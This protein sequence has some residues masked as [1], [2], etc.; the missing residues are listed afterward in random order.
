MADT[1]EQTLNEQAASDDV[2]QYLEEIRLYEQ[3]AGPW[4]T[5]A[6]KILKKY[7]NKREPN[8]QRRRVNFL[9]AMV[10]TLG[11][12]LY[13]RDPKTDISRRFSAAGDVGRV[14]ADVLEKCVSYFVSEYGFGSAMRKAVRG[15]LLPGRGTVWCRYVPHMGRVEA[16]GEN[17]KPDYGGSQV[18]DEQNPHDT[19]ESV[20]WEEVAID[21]VHFDDFGHNIAR[22]WDEVWLLWRRVFMDRS[23]L[24]QRFPDVGSKL[25]LDHKPKELTG[26]DKRVH[27]SKAT[28][29]EI[30]DK[31]RGCTVWLHK[32][33]PDLLDERQDM[34]KLEGFFPVPEPL[35]ANLAD[36]DLIPVPDYVQWQDQAMQLDELTARIASISKSLKVAGVRDASAQ[37]LDRLLSEGVENALIPVDQ[38][39]IFAE[40]GGIK[41]AVELLPMEEIAQTLLH[42]YEAR[43][44]VKEELYEVTGLSDVIRGVSDPQETATAQDIKQNFATMR[45]DD[46][47]RQVYEFA[48]DTVKIIG[49]I[50]A[51]HFALET[52][53]TISGVRLIDTKATQKFLKSLPPQAQ[54]PALAQLFPD[55][56]DYDQDELR[57]CL[58]NPTWEEVMQLLRD[59]PARR[60]RL[61]I[62]TKSTIKQDEDDEKQARVE[63]IQAVGGFIKE[64][65]AA[66]AQQPLLVPLMA[67]LLMFGVR[68]FPVGKELEETFKLTI[69]KLEQQAQNPQQKPDPDVMKIQAQQQTEQMKAQLQQ[70]A[71]QA[72]VQADAQIEQLRVASEQKIEAMRLEY[73]KQADASAQQWQ[74]WQVDQQNKAELAQNQREAMMQA[75]ID[76]MK[77]EMQ[78][79]TQ[80]ILAHI[81]AASAIEVARISAQT[82]SGEAAYE[83]EAAGEQ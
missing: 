25:V 62:E 28:I 6:R 17:L 54:L 51:N 22:T 74:A 18:T 43:D 16:L 56:A 80:V 19:V 38:W 40:K 72:K 21:F 27:G 60:F 7:K 58:A 81:K 55:I 37:G 4:E 41:G 79:Q 66:G 32:D 5:Q 36:D 12:A 73:Q 47:Q 35:F 33:W 71:Q 76:Q 48:R 30:W 14:T 42:I 52:I 78:A 82:D 64:A 53:K 68:A 13:M 46:R 44:K 10:Q 29:Y 77:M 23:E 24:K 65:M 49:E 1:S 31:K 45:L 9:W 75:H 59:E 63:F 26:A 15:Y 8:D 20:H 2:A 50:V 69:A 34:L 83:K 67:R 57:E 70:Q 61:G 39:A 3:E 11:P